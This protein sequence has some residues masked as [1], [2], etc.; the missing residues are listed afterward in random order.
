MSERVFVS[1]SLLTL[2][3]AAGCA[4]PFTIPP[5]PATVP[6]AD[7][8]VAVIAKDKTFGEGCD[9]EVIPP[10]VNVRNGQ[11]VRWT[12]FIR[13]PECGPQTMPVKIVMKWKDCRGRPNSEEPLNLD[14]PGPG[15]QV[16]R[17]KMDAV[18][19]QRCFQYGVFAGSLYKDPELI[20]DL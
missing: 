14:P 10:R 7:H 17:V 2:I 13:D 9:L 15:Y 12:L 18:K 6:A 19:E 1:I 20:I 3:L 4:R 8:S 16:A 5:V 11:S